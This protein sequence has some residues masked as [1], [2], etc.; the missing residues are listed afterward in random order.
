MLLKKVFLVALAALTGSAAVTAGPMMDRTGIEEL[1]RAE[2]WSDVVPVLTR[3][4]ETNPYYGGDWYAL[5]L[6][7]ARLGDCETA[8]PLFTRAIELGTNGKTRGMQDARIEA[9]ICT[10]AL[11][12]LDAAI[13]HIAIAQGRYKFNDFERLESD[14]RLTKLIAEPAYRQLSGKRD[15]SAVGRVEGWSSDLDYF[16]D[17]MERRHPNPFHTV[18]EED[19]RAAARELRDQLPELA[20]VEIIAGFM[21]LA[22]MIADGHTTVYPPFDGPL[23]FQMTPIWPYAFGEDWRI[24]AAAPDFADLVGARIVAVEGVPMVDAAKRLAAHLPS[25]NEMTH[26][27]LVNVALQFAE[28]AQGV[29]GAT[30]ACC[31][32]LDVQLE[33]G[34]VRT[35]QLPGGPIDRNP[36]AAWAPGHWAGV[37]PSELPLWL[38]NVDQ[39][40]WYETIDEHNMVY[41]QINQ[42][43]D[44]ETRSLEDF[45][46]ELRQQ[47]SE[48]GPRHLVLD[49]RHN[50]GGNGYLNWPFVRELVRT[51]ALEQADGLFVIVG[52]RTFSAAMLLSS[53]IEFHTDALFVGEPT[54]S[55]PQFYGEDTEFQLP[56]SK[57][58]G[59]ISSRWF[60]NRFISD[61]E[62]PWIAPDIV[63]ELSFDDLREGRDPAIEA[64]RRYL[65]SRA[66]AT[67]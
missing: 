49:L 47:F 27:W 43:R 8:A 2:R 7:H 32:T 61:D 21:R 44:S 4:L 53:M 65:E 24:I 29:F 66:S 3:A 67:H 64:I 52:R 38:R 19:W 48:G 36:M 23:A 58:A 11:G 35:V 40:H 57:L 25:D 42:I 6:A 5:G 22:S 33:S 41:A 26:K 37:Q 30:N 12:D 31:L 9:A 34:E 17:L 46:R 1:M 63:A 18:A 50:N 45:G 14:M 15:W 28:V 62:R 55:R 16:V 13:D 54:G 60:Q 10:A 59:S 51:E 39:S 20:D 56:Y